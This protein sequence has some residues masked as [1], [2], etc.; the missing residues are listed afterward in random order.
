MWT[1]LGLKWI[2][3]TLDH[4]PRYHLV[5][6]LHLF[7]YRPLTC[8]VDS[9]APF[10]GTLAYPNPYVPYSPCYNPSWPQG[11]WAEQPFTTTI[12]NDRHAPS[13]RNNYASETESPS[14][15][16]STSA[17]SSALSLSDTP[18]DGDLVEALRSANIDKTGTSHL[19]SKASVIDVH[20]LHEYDESTIIT[21]NLQSSEYT[22]DQ[23]QAQIRAIDRE[24]NSIISEYELHG[25]YPMSQI[26]SWYTT[27]DSY[28]SQA[29]G[30]NSG[31]KKTNVWSN[32]ATRKYRSKPSFKHFEYPD[33]DSVD[34]NIAKP[35]RYFSAENEC[36][37]GD[38]CT[39]HVFVIL[40]RWLYWWASEYSIHDT[41]TFPASP[42]VQ[43]CLKGPKFSGNE[44]NPLM[45]CDKNNENAEKSISQAID[46]ES[47]GD[48]EK[49][50][51]PVTWRVIGGGV[52]MGGKRSENSGG[53]KQRCVESLEERMTSKE[54]PIES[55]GGDDFDMERKSCLTAPNLQS[56][57]A[58]TLHIARP[59]TVI[60]IRRYEDNVSTFPVDICIFVLLNRLKLFPAEWSHRF[61]TWILYISILGDCLQSW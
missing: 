48:Q 6:W 41:S 9:P 20:S 26:P 39:L 5:R 47:E 17:D 37:N 36:P 55:S 51:F 12:V 50:F 28:F 22:Q 3:C 53:E 8:C 45:G 11:T 40:D 15:S 30:S 14:I 60:G 35:C 49:N 61:L 52:L 46:A 19:V 10:A 58:S 33:S 25:S 21:G 4:H 16:F 54:P 31:S 34:P 42:I 23:Q 32:S 1:N 59:Q 27:G 2:T 29:T 44:D 7:C 24:H 43:S 38:N 18:T 57:S 56:G 13:G